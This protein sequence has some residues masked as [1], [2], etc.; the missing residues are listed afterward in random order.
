M[1]VLSEFNFHELIVLR[2][3]FLF[4]IVIMVG[5]EKQH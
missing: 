2:L 1:I 5:F 3:W 4:Y